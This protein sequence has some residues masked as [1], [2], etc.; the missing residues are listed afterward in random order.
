MRRGRRNRT[1]ALIAAATLTLGS[2]ALA[3]A[4]SGPEP[5]AARSVTPTFL[6]SGSVK[7]LYPGRVKKLRLKVSN[8]FGFAI[9]VRFVRVVPR[10]RRATCPAKVLRVGTWRGP[11]R[12]P[13]HGSRRIR[14]KVRLSIDAPDAC[15][16]VRFRLRY[17]GVAVRA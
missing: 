15:Q 10:S 9:K 8:P 4:W 5:P 7:G 11:M 1:A 13:A 6:V 3:A 16:G 17:G 2:V 12:I 14:V